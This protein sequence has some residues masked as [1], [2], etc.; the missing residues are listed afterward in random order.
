MFILLTGNNYV[1]INVWVFIILI[2][3]NKKWINK[4]L[5][6]FYRFIKILISS[7]PQFPC[8]YAIYYLQ[9]QKIP[10]LHITQLR[11]I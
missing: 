10:H 4:Y 1:K 8:T 6:Y 7:E 3:T 11:I 5:K 9:F 2:E